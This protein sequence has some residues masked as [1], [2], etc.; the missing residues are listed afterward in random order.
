MPATLEEEVNSNFAIESVDQL[1]DK[2][3]VAKQVVAKLMRSEKRQDPNISMEERHRQVQQL[4]ITFTL[5]S[6]L[7]FP[8]ALYEMETNVKLI[9]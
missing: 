3:K 9:L 7:F 2:N 4:A 6:F 5:L 1:I 8:P